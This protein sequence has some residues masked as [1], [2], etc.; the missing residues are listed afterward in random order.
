M[1]GI[2]AWQV[3][4]ACG[5][6]C[7]GGMEAFGLALAYVVYREHSMLCNDPNALDLRVYFNA[8]PTDLDQYRALANLL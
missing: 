3:K 8:S 1:P 7:T 5:F 4:E 6:A 2:E